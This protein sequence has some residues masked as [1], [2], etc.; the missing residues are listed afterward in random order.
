MI[1]TATKYIPELN[2]PRRENINM[3]ISIN[4]NSTSNVFGGK[5]SNIGVIIFFSIFEGEVFKLLGRL[6]SNYKLLDLI[7]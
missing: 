7:V 3:A 5:S 4:I 2:C 6:N 1:L